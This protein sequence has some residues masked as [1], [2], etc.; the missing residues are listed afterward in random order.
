VVTTQKDA[1]KLSEYHNEL[2]DIDIF[3][4]KIDLTMDELSSF[5][6]FLLNKIN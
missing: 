3:Y 5:K 6:E 4:L 2:D 1:V